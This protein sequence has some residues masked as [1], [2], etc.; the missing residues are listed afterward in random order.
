MQMNLSTKQ[1]Q[2]TDIEEELMVAEGKDGRRNS[3]G[4]WDGQVHTAIFTM[5]DQEAQEAAQCYVAGWMGGEFWGE[6][7]RVYVWPSPFAVHPKLS[8]HC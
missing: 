3:Q 7:I 4:A 5:D 2:L 6:W 8:Q 1:K